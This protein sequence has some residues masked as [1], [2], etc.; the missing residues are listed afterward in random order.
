MTVRSLCRVRDVAFRCWCGVFESPGDFGLDTV[1][2]RPHTPDVIEHTT[3]L[4]GGGDAK[5]DASEPVHE[6]GGVDDFHTYKCT[7]GL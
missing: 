2:A 4:H 1:E 3:E 7:K 5:I 6:Y